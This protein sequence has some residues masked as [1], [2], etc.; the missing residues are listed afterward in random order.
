MLIDTS[1]MTVDQAV[2]EAIALVAAV[3]A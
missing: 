1:D 2:A 3:H